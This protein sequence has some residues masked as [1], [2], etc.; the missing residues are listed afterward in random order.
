MVARR[1]FTAWTTAALLATSSGAALAQTPVAP[2]REEIRRE[3]LTPQPQALPEAVA[4]EDGI[5]RAPCP[6]AQPQFAD[7]RFR[8][9]DVAFADLREIDPA[10]L[11]PA[12][13]EFVGREVPLATVCEIRDRAATILRREGFLAAVQVPPQRIGDDGVVRFDVLMARIAR[14]QVRGESGNSEAVLAGYLAP[15]A[16]QPVFNQ[17]DAER[18]LLL[19]RELP[20][21]SARLALR[22][23]DGAPG[24]VIGDVRVE[25]ARLSVEGNVQ[26]F[27]SP[28]AG[29][30]G[31]QLRVQ[32]NDVTGLGDRTV[33][34][35]F[36]SADFDEQ[37]V[38]NFAHDFA[39]GSDGLRLGG[40]FT[41]AW[42]DPTLGAVSPFD[43]RTMIATARASYPLLLEQARRVT[44][45]A[46][47]ELIDQEVD[48]GG[49]PLNEDRMRIAF[50]RIDA[51]ITDRDSIE[52]LSGYSAA[53][54]R[55]RFGVSAELRQG[56]DLLDATG[57]G[58]PP[59]VPVP[60]SRVQGEADATVFRLEGL[61]ELRPHPRVAWV[62]QPRLQLTGDA[63]LAYE[64]FSAGNYT[65]GRGYDP[66]A[67]IGDRGVG[68]RSELR[69]GSVLARRDDDLALQPYAFFDGAWI[70]ND[71][72]TF[73]GL[74]DEDE[75]F[76]TGAGIRASYG[77]RARLDVAL[78][79]PLRRTN[80]QASTPDPRLLVSLTVGF[81]R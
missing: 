23:G 47:F 27:G 22:P 39:V 61:A 35:V 50:A 2:T 72:P 79:V 4:V 37:L 16:E 68:F 63:L 60:Q 8:L 36:S 51:G 76:S 1:G 12:Y 59:A 9:S 65:V 52:G 40:E 13:A 70:W 54:P 41:Y 67:I 38:L 46:G 25:R 71:D 44:G 19:A 49:L 53:E 29:R 80:L 3:G 43:T 75:I 30:F 26:N 10:A 20:G 81:S 34:G 18:Q 5:E 58:G 32:I 24:E 64:E 69:I 45:S 28:A 77:D 57:P 62:F 14:L 48:F 66:G 31:G 73:L 11:R 74:G 21:F 17:R 7:I 78:A 6:L 33:F 56:L 15:L 42:N 55:W